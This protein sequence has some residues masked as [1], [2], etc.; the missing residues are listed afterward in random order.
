MRLLSL[1][2]SHFK[3]IENRLVEFRPTGITLIQGPNEVGKTSLMTAFDI[4]L[5]YADSSQHRDVEAT[6]SAGQDTST[7]I[8]ARFQVGGESFTYFKRYHRERETKLI[9][10]RDDQRHTV[11]G[12][13]AHDRVREVLSKTMDWELW[14]ALKMAQGSA[15][16]DVA[17]VAL[18]TSSSLREALD[19]V[20]GRGDGAADDTIFHRVKKERDTYYATNGKELKAVFSGLRQKL[21]TVQQDV[22]RFSQRMALAESEAERLEYLDR[23][24]QAL[25]AETGESETH[26]RATKDALVAVQ[27][28]ESEQRDELQSLRY[29]QDRA[30]EL[31]RQW[32]ERLRSSEQEATLTDDVRGLD[33]AIGEGLKEEA[34]ART[35]YIE[36]RALHDVTKIDN[37]AARRHGD[38]V[39]EDATI[40]MAQSEVSA[41]E[42]HIDRIHRLS[43]NLAEREQARNRVGMT[44][45]GLDAIRKQGHRLV[46]ARSGL[47]VGSP[48]AVLRAIK[49]LTVTVNGKS[50]PLMTDETKQ[51]SLTE[52]L[53][54]AIPAI[55]DMVVTPGTSVSVLQSKL[56]REQDALQKL[57]TQYQVDS[58]TDAESQWDQYRVLTSQIEELQDQLSGEL[59]ESDVV[60]L[61]GRQKTLRARIDEYRGRRA[62]DYSYPPSHDVARQ[63]VENAQ[64]RMASSEEVLRQSIQRLEATKGRAHQAKQML[65]TAFKERAKKQGELTAARNRLLILRQEVPDDALDA[66]MKEEDSDLE[67]AR[68]HVD[69]ISSRLGLLQPDQVRAR[70]G[71]LEIQIQTLTM[72]LNQMRQDRAECQGRIATMGGEGLYEEREDAITTRD[73]V[74]ADL[75]ALERRAEAAKLL[76]AVVSEARDAEQRRYQEPLRK[77]IRELGQVVFGKDFD[78]TL[79][80]NLAVV[81][82]TLEGNT[83]AVEVLSTGAKEQLAL[84]VRL[85]A[86]SL[87]DPAE[88]VPIILDDTLGHT[89]DDRLDLMAAVLMVVAKDCQIILLT[90]A[91]RRYT[92]IGQAHVIDLW[93]GQTAMRLG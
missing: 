84:L 43:R 3:G 57:L 31:R 35:A 18:G 30:Q 85:A 2:L 45:E 4:L 8:E 54:L 78:V 11:R 15:P 60:T 72:R 90:S 76:Y 63:W 71:Q 21:A 65:E 74:E 19:R 39:N 34:E 53:N 59:Q 1:R 47:E 67:K 80:E 61:E 83:L 16:D 55:L 26:L 73:K 66:Q 37:E 12:R 27:T 92:K 9:I 20:A 44:Q 13:E 7:E 64:Q 22:D 58:V 91:A 87:V 88:G 62:P 69:R 40:L 86:A 33:S 93:R 52:S 82:R 70:A 48:T 79:D 49:P 5:E 23:Q 32:D 42:K 38:R 51:F 89:D 24:I 41:L 46:Q 68:L 25:N 14:K 77:R 75:A 50:I 17:R 56:D 10:E 36:A 29:I 81:S 28:L 6:K